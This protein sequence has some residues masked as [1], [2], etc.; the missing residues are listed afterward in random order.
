[1]RTIGGAEASADFSALLRQVSENREG[2][3]IETGSEL[4]VALVPVEDLAHAEEAL[5]TSQ[6]RLVDA[7]ECI[8]DGFALYDAA[9]R[10]VICN[11]R[12]RDVYPKHADILTPGSRFEDMLRIGVER[13]EFADAIGREEEWIQERLAQHRTPTGPIE[14]RL[15]DGRWLRVEE[16]RTRD[17]GIVGLR[18]DITALKKAEAEL[19][20]SEE[21]F[22]DYAEAAAD[23]FWEM[24]ADLRFTYMSKNVEWLVGVPPEWHYGKTR[25]DLLGDDYDRETW[26]EHLKTLKDHRP[27]RDFVYE[28]VGEGVEPCWLRVNGVPV[29]AKGRHLHGLPRHRRGC[30]QTEAG[31]GEAARQRRSAPPSPEDAG[32]G[33][34]DRRRGAR[35]QQSPG[36]HPGQC[37]ALHDAV[38]QRQSHAA[39]RDPGLKTRCGVDPEPAGLLASAVLCGPQLHLIFRRT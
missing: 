12:Y 23:W 30:H 1:M 6:S 33:T 28:R 38:G 3:L 27:F 14:Q 24:D 17:G 11:D 20:E 36:H 5:R 25:E 34:V 8:P 2:V 15:S 10:L 22:R 21:R 26:D 4:P 35:L 31:R 39:G 13:G 7:I 16:K 32:C 9:D 29:F 37:R 19:Q 18:T